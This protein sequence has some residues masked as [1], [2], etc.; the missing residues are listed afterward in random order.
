MLKCSF[1]LIAWRVEKGECCGELGRILV[2]FRNLSFH[3]YL[4]AAHRNTHLFL[5]ANQIKSAFQH[6]C[7]DCDKKERNG[8]SEKKLSYETFGMSSA[9]NQICQECKDVAVVPPPA[10]FFVGKDYTGCPTA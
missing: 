1:D 5:H 2:C 3:E 8:V 6:K 10:S 4:S 7:N 9:I